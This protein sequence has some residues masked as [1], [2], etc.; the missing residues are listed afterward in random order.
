MT[1]DETGL[2]LDGVRSMVTENR[3]LH[4]PRAVLFFDH[5]DPVAHH[6]RGQHHDPSS[7]PHRGA[8]ARRQKEQLRCHPDFHSG[9]TTVDRAEEISRDPILLDNER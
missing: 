6:A 5:A 9:A 4:S 1:P 2:F 7:K 3:P 8:N